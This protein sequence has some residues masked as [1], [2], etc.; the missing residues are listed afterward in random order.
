VKINAQ[1]LALVKRHEGCKLEA[2]VCPAG[3][4]TIGYGH[5]GGDVKL[6]Q[7]ISQ[8]VADVILEHDL[9]D[10]EDC[11][12]RAMKGRALTS[13]QFSALVSLTFNV[14]SVNFVNSTLR[15]LALRGDFAGAAAEFPRWVHGG[16]KV[17]PG[18]VARRADERALFERADDAVA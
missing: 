7:K 2:Y 12:E 6:G 17:L 15:K 4:V 5:T 8:H 3:K 14:G 11:V 10:A 16:G 18:L 9:E 13:N 1:G